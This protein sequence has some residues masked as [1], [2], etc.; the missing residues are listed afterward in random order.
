MKDKIAKEGWSA[1]TI[2]FGGDELVWS[3]EDEGEIWPDL[4][5]S[6]NDVWKSYADDLM[7]QLRQFIENEREFE[8][9]DWE[10]QI[11][12]V[13]VKIY[14]N[15]ELEIST[16]GHTLVAKEFSK[17]IHTVIETTTIQGWRDSR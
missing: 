12:P 11:Y 16:V 2:M 14:E 8:E 1:M 4:Y 7:E 17:E 6:K 10:P 13:Y 5:S 9:V 15:G 3:M